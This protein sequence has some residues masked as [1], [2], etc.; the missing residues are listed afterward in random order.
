[1]YNQ[2]SFQSHASSHKLIKLAHMLLMWATIRET[3]A[4]FKPAETYT[5]TTKFGMPGMP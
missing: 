5:N 3:N 4:S 2:R 1:M